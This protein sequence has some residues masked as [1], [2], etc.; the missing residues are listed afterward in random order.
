MANT[1]NDGAH[2]LEVLVQ[3]LKDVE[4]KDPVFD[5]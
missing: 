5:G 4:N 1:P 3:L 2:M